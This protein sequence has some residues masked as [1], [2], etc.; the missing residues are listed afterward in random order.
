MIALSLTCCALVA[1]RGDESADH[2]TTH[3]NH[4]LARI[5]SPHPT[6][7]NSYVLSGSYSSFPR[8]HRIERYMLYAPCA[9][10]NSSALS[11]P[12]ST[13]AATVGSGSYSAVVRELMPATIYCTQSCVLDLNADSSLGETTGPVC[14]AFQSFLVPPPVRGL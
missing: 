14:G 8:T 11:T 9:T 12:N 13:I 4:P 10:Y 6:G 7:N 1:R 3:P 2:S 5:H